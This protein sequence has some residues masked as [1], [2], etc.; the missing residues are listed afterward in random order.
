MAIITKKDEKITQILCELGDDCSFE[1]FSQ[2]FIETYPGDWEK[3]KRTYK[4][5]EHRDKKGKGHPMPEPEQYM[6]NMYNVG[7]KKCSEH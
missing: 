7:K 6:K 5:H 3:I 2:K 1:E 4:Q